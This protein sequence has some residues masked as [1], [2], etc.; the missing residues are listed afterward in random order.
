MLKP[1]QLRIRKYICKSYQKTAL[2]S[3]LPPEEMKVSEWA[4]KYRML[5]SKTSAEPGPWNNSR[6][7]YLVEIMDEFLNPET[8]EIA[9]CKCTQIGGTEAELNALGYVI[10]QDSTEIGRASC[11]ERV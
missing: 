5:D 9:Y 10:Q 7:P 4:E 1:K 3:L 6:T 2:K 11:R 8:E